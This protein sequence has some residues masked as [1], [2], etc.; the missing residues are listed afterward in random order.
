MITCCYSCNL[1]F[2]YV[3]FPHFLSC[4][5]DLHLSGSW[6]LT[7]PSC[8]TLSTVNSHNISGPII[9]Q[10]FTSN[11]S[12]LIPS[13]LQNQ[14]VWKPQPFLPPPKSPNL[15]NGPCRVLLSCVKLRHTLCPSLGNYR[16]LSLSHYITLASWSH[17]IMY[18]FPSSWLL[19]YRDFS[20][21]CR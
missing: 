18:G 19:K 8:L 4:S 16:T 13:P 17:D 15:R 2:S 11:C 10:K 9:G 21:S 5:F 14:L 7:I 6:L 3:L 1:I 12:L 20:V